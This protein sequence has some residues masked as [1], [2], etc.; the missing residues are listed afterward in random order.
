M[1]QTTIKFQKAALSILLLVFTICILSNRA[2][3]EVYQ[4]DNKNVTFVK[5]QIRLSD[6]FKEIR[7]QTGLII[8]YNNTV[9]NDQEKV[10]VNFD[11]T[12]IKKV[13]AFLL[14]KKDISYELKDK[15]IL[16]KKS[17]GKHITE[18]KNVI[19]KSP[20]DSS[21]NRQNIV[22]EGKI[23]DEK[24]EPLSGVSIR[25]DGSRE[26]TLSN[27]NGQFELAISSRDYERSPVLDITYVGF[28]RKKIKVTGHNMQTIALIRKE[29]ELEQLVVV[30]YGTQKKA[31]VTVTPGQSAE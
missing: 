30:E 6:L 8:F 17:F 1:Y 21:G 4:Q 20:S 2:R 19:S 24:G 26:G 7:K 16:L 5:K 27:Q 25:I 28:L 13:M 31:T 3:A 10:D 23:E 29:N 14:D 9:L 11:Q 15:F 18:P 12:P 22:I